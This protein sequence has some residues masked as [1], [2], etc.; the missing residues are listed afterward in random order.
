MEATQGQALALQG[1]AE[2]TELISL[3]Q[4]KWPMTVITKQESS[5]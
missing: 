3:V 2:E 1:Q 4:E 5:Q